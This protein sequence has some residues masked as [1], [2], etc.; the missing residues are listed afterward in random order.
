[1]KICELALQTGTDIPFPLLGLSIRQPTIKDIAM[2]GGESIFYHVCQFLMVTKND[3]VNVEDKK[4]LDKITNFDIIMTMINSNEPEN[5]TYKVELV[6]LFALL[7]PDYEIEIKREKILLKKE[8][9]PDRVLSGEN[10]NE[11]KSVIS[12]IFKLQDDDSQ[13]YNPDGEIAT[14]LARKFE[15]RKRKLQEQVGGSKKGDFDIFS[16]MI[17]VLNIGAGLDKQELSNYTVHQLFDSFNR[18]EMYEQYKLGVR[19]QIAGGKTDSFPK[20]WQNWIK[21]IEK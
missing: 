16:R 18:F 7:F 11:F 6:Q 14:Q 17:S 12:T 5:I 3:L 15:E 21:K 8:G 10:F 9:E 4:V 20:D 1:M 2:I 19:I 13:K